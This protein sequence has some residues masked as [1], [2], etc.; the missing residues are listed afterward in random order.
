M[1]KKGTIKKVLKFVSNVISWTCFCLLIIIVGCIIWYII[2]A[3]IYASKGEKYTPY[4]SLY[5]IISPSMEPNIKVYDVILNT[6]V[7]DPSKL[8]EGDVI[9]FI[10]SGNLSNGMTITHRIIEVI[11]AKDGLRFRTKGDNN[12]TPDGATVIP[13]NILGKTL[14]RIP[15]LG[16]VQF[17]IGNKGGWFFLVLLPALGIVIYDIIKLFKVS[18]VKKKVETALEKQ[19]EEIDLEKKRKEEERKR[20]LKQKLNLEEDND[21]LDE[22]RNRA[23]TYE[24]E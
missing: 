1:D 20:E 6:R 10:S 21:I 5:T 17:L 15:Q 11:E 18:E 9:T 22:E 7:D 12:Q 8:K 16:R 2:T 13:S 24:E 14:L 23:N 3:K 19:A 4:F